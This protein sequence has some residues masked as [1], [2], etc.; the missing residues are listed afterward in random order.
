MVTSLAP[1]TILDVGAGS[2]FFS[3]WL[4]THTTANRAV[5]VDTG[6]TASRNEDVQGKT[7]AFQP[8]IGIVDADLVLMMDVLEHVEDDVGLLRDY[9]ALV[10]TGAHV[11]ITVPAFNALWSPHDLFLG[12]KRRYTLVQL[13]KVVG[14]A[15][16]Q[17]L[18]G[19]YY[20]GGIFPLAA[21][22]RMFRRLNPPAGHEPASDLSMPG[23]LVNTLL[24]TLCKAELPLFPFNRLAGLTACCLARKI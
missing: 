10:P 5:C 19:A 18:T 11:M 16:L 20:F 22:Y 2:A 4:L 15:G 1:R 13:E 21:L 3:R 7:I 14:L 23:P 12:H 24:Y 9:A 8:E 6:Y 17:I